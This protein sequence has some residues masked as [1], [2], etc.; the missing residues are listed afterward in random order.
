MRWPSLGALVGAVLAAAAA[1]AEPNADLVAPI[2]K[3]VDSFNQGDMAAAAATHATTD[4]SI[5]DEFP[6]YLW[7]GAQALETWSADLASDAKKRGIT[8]QKVEIG[9][10][11]REELAGDHAYVVVPAVY[12]FKEGGT[13]MRE[14][15]QFVFALRKGSGG[16]LIHGWAWTGPKPS[17]TGALQER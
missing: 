3:F 15:A 8:D 10:P 6:P 11:T 5:I 2:Q 16:W 12:T 7:R 1:A 9:R 13:A 4:V 17:P 14:E